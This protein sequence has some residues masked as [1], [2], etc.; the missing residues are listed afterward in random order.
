MKNFI[1]K[2]LPYFDLILFI[3]LLISIPAF[4]IF[5]RIGGRRFKI[6]R[7]L[8]KKARVYPI[9]DH[10]YYPLFN[11][12][13]LKKSLRK[14]RYLPGLNLREEKQI[15]FLQKLSFSDELIKMKLDKP[16]NEALA[17]NIN[18][19]AFKSGDAEYLYQI[20]RYL[21]PKKII[22]IGSGE[23]TKIANIAVKKNNKEKVFSCEHI[24]IEPYENKWLD[25][26]DVKLIRNLVENCDTSIFQNLEENDLLFIDSSHMIRP[27]GDVLKEYL[28]IIPILKSGVIIHVHDIFTPRDYLDEW[29]REEVYFWNEQYIL[30]CLLTNKE[31]Y[32]VVASINHLKHK[33]Y[34]SLKKVCPYLD[35]QREP[36]SF[37]FRVK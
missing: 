14:V 1:R 35:K 24:C 31:R 23:S 25:K 37:Y 36:C 7:N 12:E 22:E 29:I 30:E 20:I 3:P 17:F 15:D 10:Y 9:R 19:G 28:E 26:L 13:K 16:N 6:C 27:Q 32:E 34:S 2:I 18:N 8:L 21:K 33:Y 4:F 5:A 11:D